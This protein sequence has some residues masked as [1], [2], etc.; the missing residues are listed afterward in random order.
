MPT[1]RVRLKKQQELAES[2]LGFHFEKPPG[3]T[4]Q[5]GQFVNLTLLDPPE[6]DAKGNTRSFTLSSAP[7]EDDLMVA[8]RMRD[9]AFSGEIGPSLERPH[10]PPQ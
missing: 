1:H 9:T 10:G 6:T 8:T 5:A 2:T 3:F 4:Y 7:H